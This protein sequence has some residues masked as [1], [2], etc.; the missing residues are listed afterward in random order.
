MTDASPGKTTA[1]RRP[2]ARAA[3]LR[4]AMPDGEPR[5]P[6]ITAVVCTLNEAPNLIHVLPRIPSYVDEVLLVDGHSTDG[7]V[8]IAKSLKPDI[9]VLYQEGK[10][11]GVAM[12]YGIEQATGDIIVT[13]DADGETDPQEM[14]KFIEP[15]LQGYDFAKGSRFATGWK[16]KP[17]HRLMG[18][19][20]IANTCNALYGTRFSDLCS[21]YNAFWRHVLERAYLWSDD[22]WNYEP[23]IMA[24]VL[25]ASL[26]VVEVPHT[27]TGRA[28]DESKLSSWGQGTTTMWVLFR[29]RFAKQPRVHSKR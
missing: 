15:L 29:E 5:L 18:N 1:G 14:D 17:L 8:E 23:L 4:Q 6:P 22:G 9:R 13:L 2:R 28:G 16:H 25:R 27:F 10:G 11:K 19:F 21:G 12:R 7:T 26:K 24:R 3:T 20:V